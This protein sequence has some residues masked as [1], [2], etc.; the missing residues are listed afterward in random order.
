MTPE[1]N[2]TRLGDLSLTR[3]G[4]DSAKISWKIR[5]KILKIVIYS[6]QPKDEI[7][8]HFTVAGMK[9]NASTNISGL[10]PDNRYYFEVVSDSGLKT[11]ISERRVPLEGSV[12]FRDLGGYETADGRRIKWGLVFRSDNLGRITDRDV[13]FLQRM[14]IRLVCDFRTPAEAKNLPDRFPRN[15]RVKYLHLPIQHGEFDPANTFER[16]QKGDIEWMTE[17]FMIKGYIKN[18]DNFAPVWSTLFNCLS[19]RSS[20]PIVFHCTGGKDR[21]GVCAALILLTLGVSEETVITDHGLSNVYIAGVLEKIYARIR[22][23]GVDPRQVSSYFTAP[24]NAIVAF[25]DHIRQ[26]YGSAAGYLRKKAGIEQK[27]IDQLKKDLLE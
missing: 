22:S 15:G 5:G 19:D 2:I 20:R 27:I 16:I 11:T 8:H 4:N 1:I 18:I 7:E 14:G 13:A 10:D 12:N 23:A 26:T 17:E 9:E 21:A 6:R 24:Q 3:T 25:I